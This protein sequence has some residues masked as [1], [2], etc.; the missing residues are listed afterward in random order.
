[1]RRKRK[2]RAR[3]PEPL[4]VAAVK[5]AAKYGVH[6]TAKVLRLDYYRLKKRVEEDAA[7]R[8][9]VVPKGRTAEFVELPVPLARNVGECLIE[10]EDAEG[11]KM[12]MHLTGAETPDPAALGRS[13]WSDRP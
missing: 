10:W 13:F 5:V 2:V 6:R 8:A 1:W 12:R 4:W 7:G 9:E 11:A 3:I